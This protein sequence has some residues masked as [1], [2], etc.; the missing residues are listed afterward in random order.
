MSLTIVA[1]TSGLTAD[2]LTIDVM[3]RD[4]ARPRENVID[5]T[6]YSPRLNATNRDTVNTAAAAIYAAARV[7][8]MM[9]HRPELIV[10]LSRESIRERIEL[11]AANDATE[12]GID[13]ILQILISHIPAA[14]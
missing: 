14:H 5:M 2:D 6:D 4:S 10:I 13:Q 9:H 12:L 11:R 3:I 7:L 8:K 1:T